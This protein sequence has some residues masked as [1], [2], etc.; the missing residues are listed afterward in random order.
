MHLNKEIIGQKIA[1]NNISDKRGYLY[2][3]NG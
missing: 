2:V 3:N 1:K